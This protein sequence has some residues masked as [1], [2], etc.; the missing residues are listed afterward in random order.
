[1]SEEFRTVVKALITNNGKVLIGRKED[2]DHP[3]AGEWH[4][5]GG[6]LEIGEHPEEAV[7]RE[8]EEETGLEVEVHQIVDVSTFSWTDGEKDSLQILYHTE[9]ESR[10]AEASS[11]LSDVK[12]VSPEKLVEELGEKDAFR[13]KERDNQ[14]K[15]LEKMKKAPIF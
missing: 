11:D 13:M 1:M 2:G 7:E 3:I 15:F 9:A 8:V 12:W 5:L 4:I 10:E 14:Q 6:H